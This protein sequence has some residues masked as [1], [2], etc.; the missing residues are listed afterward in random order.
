MLFGRAVAERTSRW[1]GGGGG[2]GTNWKPSLSRI[3][4]TSDVGEPRALELADGARVL[5]EAGRIM[6]SARN[7]MNDET[8]FVERV[9]IRPT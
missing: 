4:R 9:L 5:A 6:I 7:E 8:G 1:L 3:V 2:A